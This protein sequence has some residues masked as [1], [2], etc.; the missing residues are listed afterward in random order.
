MGDRFATWLHYHNESN[1]TTHGAKPIM[2]APLRTLVTI[3]KRH[4]VGAHLHCSNNSS[5]YL[6]PLYKNIY[7][8]SILLKPK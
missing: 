8:S 5:N 6:D 2:Q 1:R 7:I 4:L 3:L